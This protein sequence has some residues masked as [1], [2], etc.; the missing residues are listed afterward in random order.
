MR[1]S[2]ITINLNNRD[3]LERT[4]A[5]VRVQTFRDFE[6]IVVDGGSSDGSLDVIRAN[7]DWIARWVSEPDSGIYNAMNKGIAMAAGDYLLFLNS[8]D[9]LD[10]AGVLEAMFATDP[11]GAGMIYGH[12]RYQKPDGRWTVLVAP[13][14]MTMDA[15]YTMRINHQSTF[16]RRDLF[17]TVGPYDEGVRFAADFDYMLRCL[18]ADVGS[19]FVDVVV[20]IYEGGGFS[21]VNRWLA[22]EECDRLW[23]RHIG[24]GVLEDYQ[25]FPKLAAEIRRLRR[26]EDWI[27]EAKRKPLWYNLGLVCKWRW[28]RFVGKMP[29]RPGASSAAP[30]RKGRS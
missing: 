21:E 8:G 15:V 26:A 1:L 23:A 3:G 30:I 22:L 27:E 2:I 6:Q 4:L 10:S 25:Q 28:D 11:G 24:P 14:R 7:A 20:S 17:T 5:S 29:P 9:C 19:R 12:V 18:A 13:P 16:F